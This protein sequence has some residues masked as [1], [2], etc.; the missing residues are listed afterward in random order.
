MS[1]FVNFLGDNEVDG[2]E[3][4]VPQSGDL[5]RCL[6]AWQATSHRWR[7][8]FLDCVL[9]CSLGGKYRES[10]EGEWGN[11]GEKSTMRNKVRWDLS[12]SNAVQNLCTGF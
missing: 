10:T 11:D 4:T 5:P 7:Y 6:P 9:Y 2:T 12:I 3:S 1:K 8:R